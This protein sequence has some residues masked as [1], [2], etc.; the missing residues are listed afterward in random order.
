MKYASKFG[1]GKSTAN[2]FQEASQPSPSLTHRNLAQRSRLLSVSPSIQAS[3]MKH[4][5]NTFYANC[6]DASCPASFRA[7]VVRMLGAM[8]WMLGAMVR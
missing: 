2:R 4:V 7:R 6:T 1:K 3:D 8:V 5:I